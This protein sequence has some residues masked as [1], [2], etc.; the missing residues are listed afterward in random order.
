MIAAAIASATRIPS[1]QPRRALGGAGEPVSGS[2]ACSAV[3]ASSSRAASAPAPGT[4]MSRGPAA[5]K[6]GT[7]KPRLRRSKL[8]IPSSSRIPWISWASARLAAKRDLH[9]IAARVLG[10]H[11]ARPLVRLGDRLLLAAADV[12][13]RHLAVR[14][15]ALARA[16]TCERRSGRRAARP[17]GRHSTTSSTSSTAAPSI[18]KPRTTGLAARRASRSIQSMP[19]HQRGQV[20]VGLRGHALGLRVR[21]V[22]R[23]ISSPR[24]SIS[25][26]DPEQV[27]RVDLE[28][29]RALELVAGRVE[30]DRAAVDA[31]RRSR[32]TRS[33]ASARAWAT[34]SVVEVARDAS[35]ARGYQRASVCHLTSTVL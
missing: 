11:L 16:G 34:S 9:R 32:S 13:E 14:A 10:L 22:D 33:G 28:A 24:S 17:P 5:R 6:S 31:R 26:V 19:G 15:E 4:R 30:V 27:V 35:P 7:S 20:D 18:A 3:P 1:E 8:G 21:V 23:A 2:S 12:D 29:Q 25:V